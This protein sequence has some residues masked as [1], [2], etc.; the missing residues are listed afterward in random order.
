M[1]LFSDNWFHFASSKVALMPDTEVSQ[2]V[3]R[4]EL[5]YVLFEPASQGFFRMSAPAWRFVSELSLARSVDEVWQAQLERTPDT[6]PAQ[7]EVIS[8]LSQLYQNG[9]LL[10]SESS[11]GSKQFHRIKTQKRK[12]RKA[13]LLNFLFFRIRLLNPDPL[14]EWM[15]PALP[16]LVSKPVAVIWLLTMLL[17]AE[18]L[19]GKQEQ[20]ISQGMNILAFDNLLL[21]YL[22]TFV[23]KTLHELGHGVVCKHF[24]GVVPHAGVMLLLFAPVPYVDAS[25]T[26]RFGSR[27]QRVLVGAAGMITE[28]WL[29]ALAAMIWAASPPGLVNALMYNVMFVSS[30]TTLVFNLNPLMRFDGYYIFSDLI[31]Q[32]NLATRSKT[33]FRQ[34]FERRF[35]HSS[36]AM[37]EPLS[38][39]LLTYHILSWSYRIFILTGILLFVSDEYTLIGFGLSLFLISVW[40]GVPLFKGVMKVLLETDAGRKGRVL[41]AWSLY[42]VV[43]LLLLAFVP[44]PVNVTAPGVVESNQLKQVVT[45]SSGQ[46]KEV[47]VS[48]GQPVQTG[49]ILLS[50]DNPELAFELASARAELVR[51]EAMLQQARAMGDV[52]SL[53]VQAHRNT[54]LELIA[55]LER[56]IEEQHIRADQNGIWLPEEVSAREGSWISEGSALGLI[57]DPDQLVFLAVIAQESASLLFSQSPDAEQVEVRLQGMGGHSLQVSDYQVLPYSQEYLPSESLSLMSGGEIASAGQDEKGVRAAEP[58]FL[59]RAHL[60]GHHEALLPGRTGQVRVEL[61]SEPLLQQGWR[62]VRQ[63]FQSRYQL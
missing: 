30:V 36:I 47:H 18:S 13:R 26:W 31:E 15:K 28:L 24:G 48:S 19:A 40:W 9:M 58:F 60:N 63:F 4:G 52:D 29:A 57:S 25:S 1:Q 42:F 44:V 3:Y 49:D 21:L 54:A 20:L 6:V 45:S 38:W 43:P 14:L 32:P 34:W 53:P 2:Q 11:D 7:Q 46:L 51:A 35:Y 12:E 22:A 55:N 59:V 37:D 39:F 10:T 27:W 33:M 56:K 17:A 8:V 50:L 61:Q 41:K 16:W 5:W 23:V 62:A